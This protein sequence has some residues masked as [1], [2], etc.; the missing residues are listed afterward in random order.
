[1]KLNFGLVKQSDHCLIGT[2]QI[3]A[4]PGLSEVSEFNFLKGTPISLMQ[5][6]KEFPYQNYLKNCIIELGL[7]LSMRPEFK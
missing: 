5:K 2:Y 6:L 3:R 7:K 4:A 1:M